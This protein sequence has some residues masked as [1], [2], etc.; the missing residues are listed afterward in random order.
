MVRDD[1]R[2]DPD[3]VKITDY[4]EQVHLVELGLDR[5]VR[6]SA[7]RTHEDGPLV[8]E[9]QEMPLGPE[10]GVLQAFLN[11]VDSVDKVQGVVPALDAAFRMESWRR[12]EAEKRRA[13]IEKQRR[14]EEERR[15]RE[16]R[17]A[18]I[19]QQL[20]DGAG[21][22]AMALVDFAEAARAALAI[23]DATYL[24]HKQS[25]RKGEMVVRF[26]YANRQFECTCD[27]KTMQIIDAGICLTD[28]AT[29]RK[30]DTFFTLESLP[31]V[32]KEADRLRKLVVFRHVGD[33]D[34]GGR[35]DDF[36]D[37]D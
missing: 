13:E 12:L 32:I 20:G 11:R 2:V 22:R 34:D 35:D 37:D 26:R 15:Q 5:F 29:G 18:Q 17:R 4:A 8:Y 21:R 3:P 7:G 23:G 24:D 9:G 16:E 31:S 6:V 36:E 19:V 28:H 1:A 30:G 33:Y 27:A 25:T 14:E 10:E